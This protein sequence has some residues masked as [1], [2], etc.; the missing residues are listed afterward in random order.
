MRR[1]PHDREILR[2]AAL[3]LP[4]LAAEPT[5]LLVDTAIVGHLGT[6]EL[7]ALALAATVLGAL[8]AL[9]NFLTYGTTAQVARLHGAGEHERAGEV[10]AQ[11]VWL[12]LAIGVVL[13]GA[14]AALADPLMALVGG[15]GET[16]EVAARYLRLSLLG[17]PFALLALSGQGFLRGVGDLRT[18]LVVVV[19]AN[20]V[21]A[22]LEVVLVYGLDW[23]LDGSALGTVV[24]QAGMGGAFAWLLLR[25]PAVSRRPQPAI[26]RR[27]A[28]MG[29]HIVVRTGSLL[30]SFTVASAVLARVGEPSLAAHQIAFQ[31]FVFLALVLD[32]VAIAG[33][34]L[35]GR[36]LGAGDAEGAFAAA[37]RMCVWAFAFGALLALVLLA[38]TSVVPGLFTGDE[39]VVERAEEL[40]PLFA[41]LQLP[42]AV[43]F[44]LD[45]ILIGAGDT[46]YL[47]WAMAASSAVFVPLALLADSV[48]EMWWA[49]VALMVLRLVATGWRFA[50][51]RWVV[52]GAG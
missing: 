1:S 6:R 47:A 7:A 44:A 27:L 31:L 23:G 14:C 26:L 28:R 35:T 19:V 52:L 30:A 46:R 9:C 43:V 13:A 17:L 11:A 24:A 50:S 4:A 22:V 38:T 29:V 39:A 21:N 48:V 25:A 37:R 3:A 12:A 42:G 33:Q 10:A 36:A 51:R 2:L 32:A 20:A 16:A 40:W 5:Y 34:V 49:L 45:G 18:P 41:L 15:S 8:T